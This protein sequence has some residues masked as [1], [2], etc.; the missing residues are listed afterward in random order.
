MSFGV[1]FL[2]AAASLGTHVISTA[3]QRQGPVQLNDH[4]E[5]I[6]LLSVAWGL[7]LIG[8]VILALGV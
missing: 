8:V 1:V 2:L 7:A 3:M 4:H 5:A 6:G